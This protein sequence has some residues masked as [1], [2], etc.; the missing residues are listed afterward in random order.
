MVKQVL[1]NRH[2]TTVSDRTYFKFHSCSPSSNILDTTFCKQN[3]HLLVVLISIVQRQQTYQINIV[4]IRE[5]TTVI[6]TVLAIRA[7]MSIR[8]VKVP[9]GATVWTTSVTST[10]LEHQLLA[11]TQ[12]LTMIVVAVFASFTLAVEM[13]VVADFL[14]L[15]TF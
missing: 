15:H 6:V 10:L 14:I 1:P 2:T 7:D 4:Y 3:Q 11:R 13:V 9:A 12:A 5:P 8:A